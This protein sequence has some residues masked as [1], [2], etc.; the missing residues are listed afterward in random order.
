MNEVRKMVINEVKEMVMNEK[1]VSRGDNGDHYSLCGVLFCFLALCVC[2][3]VC[4]LSA[5]DVQN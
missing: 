1:C 2:V 5:Y 4:C 3:C